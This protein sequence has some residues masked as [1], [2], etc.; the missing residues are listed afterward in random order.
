MISV[1]IDISKE[2]SKICAL[3]EGKEIIWTPFDVYHNKTG[4]KNLIEKLRKLEDE[5]KIVLEAT[6]FYHQPLLISLKEAGFFV[7]VIN[8]LK[9]KRFCQALS[10]R[11]IKTDKADSEHIAEYGLMYWNELID[12]YEDEI[13]YKELRELNRTYQHYINQRVAQINYLDKEIE[14]RH[15]GLKKLI[16]HSSGDFSKDKLLD[17]IERWP[18]N[19]DILKR[20]E[21]QFIKE[22]ENWAK[23]K[24]YHP[25]ANKAKA[26]YLNALESIPLI[27]SSNSKIDANILDSIKI[28]RVINRTLNNILTQMKEIAIE[29]EEYKV[30]IEFSGIGEKLAVQIVAEIGDMRKFKNKKSLISFAGIDAPP[31]QSGTFNGTNRKISKR[32]NKILRKTLYLSIV[33]M[34]SSKDTNN[35]IYKYIKK[36]EEEGKAKNVANI[37]GINKFLRI[38]YSKVMAL[39]QEIDEL[40]IAWLIILKADRDRFICHA[41]I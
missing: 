19:H 31:Y 14:R 41:Q 15:P 6:G 12:Y 28:L 18:N 35:E 4:I 39:K 30:A 1:G 20:T 13:K 8:P 26:I 9:M 33:C 3:K 29:L 16:P 22:Y 24:G 27:S 10:F 7:S 17:F 25:N 36:K 40:K 11:N 2:K 37:A 23:K 21:K 34:K 32:G 38:F 5:T